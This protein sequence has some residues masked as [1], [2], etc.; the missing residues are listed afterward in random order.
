MKV[1][2]RKQKARL[3]AAEQERRRLALILQEVARTINSV[4]E[5]GMVFDKILEQLARLVEY[6]KASIM[7]TENE[8]LRLVAARGFKKGAA[9]LGT[10]IAI[11]PEQWI[12]KVLTSGQS[13]TSA[14]IQQSEGSPNPAEHPALRK[15]HGWI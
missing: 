5:P 7:L 8:Q 1:C 9:G 2:K 10:T 14:D 3:F 15:V 11:D 4:L 12:G 6:D 13:S